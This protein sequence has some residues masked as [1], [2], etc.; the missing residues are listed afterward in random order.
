MCLQA[1]GRV[2]TALHLLG[3]VR[4]HLD[5]SG[6][7]PMRILEFFGEKCFGLQFFDVAATY[8][9]LLKN[10]SYQTQL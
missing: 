4:M 2:R 7:V 8:K 9:L 6:G 1:F 10:Y 3:C 5:E